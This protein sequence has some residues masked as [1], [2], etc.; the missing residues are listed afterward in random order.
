MGARQ[1]KRDV[2]ALIGDYIGQKLRENAFDPKGKGTSTV[3]DDL[4]HYDLAINVA[5]WWLDKD[6]GRDVL[7]S[8]I[9]GA[10]SSSG[11]R[12]RYP[13]R[14]ER[15]AMILSSFAG[16]I[17]SSLPVDD[18]LTL[19]RCKPAASY[20]NQRSKKH[21]QK[22]ERWLS[23]RAKVNVPPGRVSAQSSSS[24]S[25]SSSRSFLSATGSS[26]LCRMSSKITFYEDRN[27]QGRSYECDTDC[28][29]MHPH[30]SRC[31]SI[32][33]ESG[34]WVLYEKPNYT[35]YQYVL[36]RGEYPDYQRW[37]GY[38]DTIRSCR[39]FSYT[40]EGPYRMRIYERPNFQ[41][42][43]ME[44]SEDCESVQDHFRS[45]DIYSCNVMDGYWTLYE[46]PNYRGR[47]YFMRPG[48]YRKFSDWGATCAT[49]GSFRRITEF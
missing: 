30:F 12:A 17:M 1:L 31:N 32:K 25:S 3:L 46:H 14:R 18:I 8:N 34:C 40:S 23:E 5:L 24:S 43:M 28:P 4:A 6:G 36:T 26:S 37:M 13:N 47:Q 35:G 49:T 19:Y 9:I 44:F 45:R 22:L 39:T 41:G 20:P 16:I 7:D 10:T 2:E 48:E 38:N 15:E 21:N 29:D 11:G 42:Q 27:F 33:V